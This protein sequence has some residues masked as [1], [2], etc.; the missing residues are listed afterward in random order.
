MIVDAHCDVLLELL[1]DDA[2]S[3]SELVRSDGLFGRYW[4]PRLAAGGVGV[5]VCPLYGACAPGPGAAKR[6]LAQEAVLRRAVEANAE[7]VCVARTRGDLA[8]SRLRLVVSME[9]VEPLEGDPAA[10]APWY[11]RGVRSASL[12]W[13][14]ANAFAGGIATPTQGL[15]EAG[16]KLVEC[17]GELAIILD[18][19]HASEQ[20]WRDVI[21]TGVPFSVTHAGC[22]AVH[23]HP[24][25]L[26]DWQLEALA[27]C[28]GV[29]GI[30]ALAFVVDPDEPTLGRWVDHVEHAVAV[31][32]IEHVGLGSDFVDQVPSADAQA[33]RAK[34][35]LG[36][37][38]FTEPSD[39]PALVA[40]LGHR[41]YD[42]DGLRAIR[43]GN[44]LRILGAAL[45]G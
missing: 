45:P 25:N 5:Q 16:R 20:T 40:A 14:H 27:A 38:G 12:T 31:M 8:D 26:A 28:G 22:R 44:W 41:G 18:L 2:G 34:R 21:E 19:A 15:T 23:D 37:E 6:A 29:L 17:F 4:L 3:P 30:M 43:S 1:L 36:L 10:F 13:N 33:A 32:G 39:Y 9:G 7:R 42:G 11:E 24:R 35:R